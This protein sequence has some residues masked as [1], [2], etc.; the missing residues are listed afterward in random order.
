MAKKGGTPENLDKIRT[1]EEA[2]KEEETVVLNLERREG[3]KGMQN[4]QQNWFWIWNAERM[5]QR[6]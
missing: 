1:T 5:L 3:E 4:R 6:T 2:R